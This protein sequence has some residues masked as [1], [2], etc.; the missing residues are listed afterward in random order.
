MTQIQ[1]HGQAH[2]FNSDRA[3]PLPSYHRSLPTRFS[4]RL[5]S[6]P[7]NRSSGSRESRHGPNGSYCGFT[8]V[9]NF[10]V[11]GD[12]YSKG[13]KSKTG[14]MVAKAALRIN[15]CVPRGG[16]E[17]KVTETS[18]PPHKKLELRGRASLS[19]LAVGSATRTPLATSVLAQNR[20]CP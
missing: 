14:L 16:G 18:T 8:A 11:P 2:P 6:V 10:Q 17:S 4:G 1:L 15:N 19:L 3:A 7:T 13:I 9:M 20:P 12:D 5:P